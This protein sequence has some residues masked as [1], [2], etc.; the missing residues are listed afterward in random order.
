[1]ETLIFLDDVLIGFLDSANQYIRET[2]SCYNKVR[3]LLG[4]ALTEIV[5][6][7]LF[8]LLRSSNII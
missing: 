6:V 2:S 3:N 4:R 1:M 7:D 8:K 5:N